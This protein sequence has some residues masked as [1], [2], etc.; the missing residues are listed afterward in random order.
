MSET[1]CP[2][3]PM[4]AANIITCLTDKDPV[5]ALRDSLRFM[6]VSASR[7]FPKLSSDEAGTIADHYL[8]LDEFLQQ[9]EC[10]LEQ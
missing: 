7:E 3:T 2:P 5:I 4:T 1:T 9:S 6:Y 10:W 8:A